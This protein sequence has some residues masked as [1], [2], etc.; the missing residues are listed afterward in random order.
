M[1]SKSVQLDTCL[2][3]SYVSYIIYVFF[4]LNFYISIGT[5]SLQYGSKSYLSPLAKHP[6]ALIP[7]YNT[8]GLA[9]PIN[10][11]NTC[12]SPLKSPFFN[13]GTSLSLMNYSSNS[14]FS[15]HF[16]SSSIFSYHSGLYLINKST[17]SAKS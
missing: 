15:F 2:S 3:A 5:T 11:L 16:L 17:A 9:S 8:T 1:A 4:S 14:F 13:L 7:N 12:I 10:F 6:V